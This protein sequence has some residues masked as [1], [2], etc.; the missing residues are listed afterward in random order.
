[1]NQV[2]GGQ[3]LLLLVGVAALVQIVAQLLGELL[4]RE[5]LRLVEA[6]LGDL[7]PVVPPVQN[8]LEMLWLHGLCLG[9]ML[10]ALRHVQPVKPGL[11]G[12]VVIVKEQNVGGDG[13][14]GREHAARQPD[15]GV[16]IELPQQLLFNAHLGV[17]GAE[18]KAVRQD[19]RRPAILFQPVHNHRHEQVGGLAAGQVAGE[20]VLHVRL[21]AAAVGGIH[22]YHVHL[23]VLGVV[24]HI[25]KQGIR[26]VHL[27]HIQP[28]KQKVGHAEHIGELLFLDAVDGIAVSFLVLCGFHL[29][30]Q[31]LQPADDKAAGAAGKVGH[32]LA[33]F[34]ADDL[35]HEIRNCAGRIKLTGGT[36]ALQLL[37]DGLVNLAEGVA[38][39]IVAEVQVVD[40]VDDLP[41]QYAVLHVVVG[42]G[43]GGLHDGLF[44]GGGRAHRQA[45]Q[46]EEQLVVHKIQQSVA[47]EGGAG[48]V[49][50]CP[51]LPAALFGNDGLIRLIIPFPVL[52]LCIV[53]LQKQHPGN[54]L[55]ALCVAV[56]TGIVAHDVP[57]PFYKSR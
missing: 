7:L 48:F 3:N 56:D 21:L 35:R 28:M 15:D 1:M 31:L 49:I 55:D 6:V 8:R 32:G 18:Q 13:G 45:F 23:V 44:D 36:G 50:V 22:Q 25:V 39:L 38:F 54:L 29:L 34:G 11:L 20:M 46:R 51:V 2:H 27:G 5:P 26:V 40:H 33:D 47:G 41:Q 57:Q 53:H 10:V 19:H 30:V 14:I 37:Q 4:R 12:G 42:I 52:L 16:Q 17:V 9:K 43:K 24:Q